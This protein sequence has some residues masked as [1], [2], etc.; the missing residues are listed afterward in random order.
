MPSTEIQLW[1]GADPFVGMD[2]VNTM[3]P[4]AWDLRSEEP[5][6]GPGSEGDREL[7]D[8]SQDSEP[9]GETVSGVVNEPETAGR[10]WVVPPGGQRVEALFVV[11]PSR[12][13]IGSTEHEAD[14]VW[15]D[16]LNIRALDAIDENGD[17][18]L[19]QV[20]IVTSDGRTI[21]A[22]WSE[23]FCGAVVA[24]LQATVDDA[25]PGDAPAEPIETTAVEAQEP[26]ADDAGT[27]THEPAVD[28]DRPAEG[29][30]T[31]VL[32]L[33]DVTYLSGF[34]GAS[35]KRKHCTAVLSGEGI[36]VSGP[37]LAEM[38]LAWDTVRSV[39]AQNSDEA[40]FRTNTKIH[41]D[42]SALV[43]ECDEDVTV[44]LEARDCPTIPLRQAIV[45]LLEGL[46]VTVK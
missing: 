32:E 19:L 3:L 45:T 25:D 38:R 10:G 31:G 39:E 8:E 7:T 11:T 12:L 26:T 18:D 36:E 37:G 30:A 43:L 42:S 21:R 1:V 14:P 44:M 20:E 33:E 16:L 34:P 29:Q 2:P 28:G 17:E 41:R 9:N 24:A 40:R 4:V 15:I 27:G 6:P 5:A 22:G 35:R 46:D 23:V 13:G